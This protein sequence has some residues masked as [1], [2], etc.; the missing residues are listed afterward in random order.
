MNKKIYFLLRIS[1][2]MY[3][4]S[5]FMPCLLTTSEKI[6][7]FMCLLAG[8][9]SI[10]SDIWLFLI[11]YSNI[12][13]FYIVIS[14]CKDKNVQIILPVLLSI[15]AVSML[16]HNYLEYDIQVSIVKYLA[17]YYMW[18]VSYLIVLLSCIFKR[19]KQ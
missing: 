4:A 18:G 12:L 3:I 15:A 13:Y 2:L 1:M 6:Y 16:F 14:L 10:I 11:W 8:G 7:G 5:C 19:K 9:I 17:G